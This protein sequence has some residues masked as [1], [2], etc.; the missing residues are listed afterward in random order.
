[1]AIIDKAAPQIMRKV[2][3]E[4]PDKV[5][6]V[7]VFPSKTGISVIRESDIFSLLKVTV[8]SRQGG[9]THPDSE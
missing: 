7:E 1:M 5:I 8:G 3:L 9:A 6:Q 2:K 4:N